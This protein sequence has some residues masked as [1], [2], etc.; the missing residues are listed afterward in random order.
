[1][2]F[3][4]GSLRGSFV[5]AVACCLFGAVTGDRMV[6]AENTPS[7]RCT[8]PV[9]RQLD[10]WVG[11]WDVFDVGSPNKAAHARID[12]ILGGCVVREDYQGMDG[13]EA[14]VSRPTTIAAVSGI[15]PG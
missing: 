9:Y 10:F 4:F 6:S 2:E 1:M 11:D 3:A 12:S 15:R 7:V 14:K 5:L 8:E 13:H